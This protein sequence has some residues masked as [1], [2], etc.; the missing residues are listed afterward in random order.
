[1]FGAPGQA[2]SLANRAADFGW[3][4][5]EISGTAGVT[6]ERIVRAAIGFADESG[7]DALSMRRL[8]AGLDIKAMSLYTYVASKDD[9]LALMLDAVTA[10]LLLER[11]FPEG[12]REATAAVSHQA[13]E[14]YLDHPWM[15]MAQGRGP[16]AGPNELK[17]AEQS[18]EAMA[19]LDLN[20]ADGT[21]ALTVLHEWTSG[22]ALVAVRI[23]AAEKIGQKLAPADLDEFPKAG[24]VSCQDG[25]ITFKAG[26]EVV[27]NGIEETFVV[28]RQ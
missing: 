21:T 3:E 5:P 10:E 20:E 4:E 25:I 9:L 14:T 2:L 26:L 15:L 13:Y 18:S 6:R 11:P 24:A 17:R 7:L 1:M 12:W 19:N 22:H 8:A 28:R 27:L 23:Q 16:R